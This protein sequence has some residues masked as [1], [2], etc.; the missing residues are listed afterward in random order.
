MASQR[1]LAD[2]FYQAIASGDKM[3]ALEVCSADLDFWAPGYMGGRG[4][5]AA[6]TYNEPF[7]S[8]F[9]DAKVT[10]TNQ[11]ES[12]NTVVSEITYTGTHTGPLPSP[13][14]PVPPTGK[15]IDLPGCGIARIEAGKIVSFRG[16][17][18]QLTLMQQLGLMPEPAAP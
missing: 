3:E 14:G 12:G 5:D 2:R 13:Q 7:V 15:R 9:P 6:W 1:E 11:V 10:I 4:V 18:D 8:A 17:F 16:Y